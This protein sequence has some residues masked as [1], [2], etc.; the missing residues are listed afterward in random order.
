MRVWQDHHAAPAAVTGHA[1]PGGHYVP[2]EAPGEVV[3]A[4]EAFLERTR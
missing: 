1:V 4:V 3:D 2:E